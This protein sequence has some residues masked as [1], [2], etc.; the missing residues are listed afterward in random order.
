MNDKEVAALVQQGYSLFSQ[1][2]IPGVL[3][4]MS[5][6]VSW[7]LPQVDNVPFTGHFQGVEGVARFFS[8]L[9]GALDIVK[10]EPREFIAQGN[11]VLVLGE[12]RYRV[13]GQNE[14]F[15]TRWVDVLT[16]DNGAISS[17]EQFADTAKLER[18]FRAKQK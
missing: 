9:A 6:N 5:P 18:A 4:L 12:S 2:D 16:V 3:K 11:K 7:E 13:K 10:F 15:D 17:Y 14:E 8:A 1:G